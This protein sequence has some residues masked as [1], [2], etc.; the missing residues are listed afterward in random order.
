[1]KR[2]PLAALAASLI[3]CLA[4]GGCEE[5]VT[6]SYFAVDVSIDRRTVDPDL[7]GAIR[8]CGVLVE[9]V[10]SERQ[11]VHSLPC[12]R[13]DRWELGKF[14]YSLAGTSGQV[15]FRVTA[16]N[17]DR[18]V[19]AEGVVGPVGVVPNKLVEAAVTLVAVPGAATP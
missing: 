3:A 11:D 10:G 18:K 14:E 13:V 5:D 7:L 16:S 19:L 12:S 9:H 1:M 2:A 15:R 6:Y 17:L 4:A 8:S